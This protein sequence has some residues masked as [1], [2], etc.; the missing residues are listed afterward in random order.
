MIARSAL[1]DSP[2]LASEKLGLESPLPT[3]IFV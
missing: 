3:P 1:E 2:Y